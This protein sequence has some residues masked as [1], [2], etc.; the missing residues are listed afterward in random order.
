MYDYSFC[1]TVYCVINDKIHP[2]RLYSFRKIII[3]RRM[4][5]V[6]TDLGLKNVLRFTNM[7]F[8][9]LSRLNWSAAGLRN[10]IKMIVPG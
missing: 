5:L 1:E 8:V 7:A 6:L 2:I 9:F 10:I 4:Y 3:L